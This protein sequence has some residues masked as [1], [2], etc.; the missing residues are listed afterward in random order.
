MIKKGDTKSMKLMKR[1]GSDETPRAMRRSVRLLTGATRAMSLVI[2]V[3]VIAFGAMM[4]SGSAQATPPGSS[5]NTE[6]YDFYTLSSNV[7]A[8]FSEA[9]KPGAKSGLSED[10]GWTNIAASASTGGDLLGYGDEN[11]SSASGWLISKTTGASNVVGYDSLRAKDSEGASYKGVLEYTQYG[12]LLNALGLDST[13]TGLNLHLTN[14][15]FGGIMIMLYLLAGGIDTI[16][17]AVVWILD[18]LNPFRVFYTGVSKASA[19]MADGMT[20][21]QG[22][23]EW[24]K[25]LDTWFSGWYQALVN[26][27]WTVLTPLF[28]FTFLLSALMWKKGQALSGLKKL[29]VRVLFLAFGLPLIGSLYTASLSVMKDATAG[30]GMGSTRVILATFVDFE[31]WAKVNR[32]AV[33]NGAELAWDLNRQAPTG[34][35][36]NNL[37]STSVAINKQSHAGAFDSI[38]DINVSQLGSISVNDE[39]NTSGDETGASVNGGLGISTYGATMDMLLRYMRSDTYQASDFETAIKGRLSRE[40][41]G[42]GDNGARIQKCATTWFNVQTDGSTKP[43]AASGGCSELKASQ[44]PILTVSGGGL[45]AQQYGSTLTFKTEGDSQPYNAVVPGNANLSPLAMYNYLN[46]SF[47]KNALTVYSSSNA[48]SKATRE[49]HGSVNLV[50]S[51]GVNWLYWLNSSVTLLCFVVLGLGYAFGML[52]GAIKNSLHIITAV[53]FA[54]IGSLAGIAKVLIYTFTMITEIIGTMFIYRLVQEIIVS[55]PS[56]FEGGLEHMY[57]S[58]GGFGDFLRN[59]GY[60]TLF[61]AIVS[62][63]VLLIL[64]V[65]MMH[66]RGAFVKGLNEAVTKIVDKFLDTNVLPPSAGG[67][68]M[69]LLSGAG[70]G[71]GSAAANRLMSGRGGLGGSKAAGAGF[72]HGLGVAGGAVA[73][74]SSING[75]D[76][77][78]EVGPGALGS[79][80]SS[81]GGTGGGGL[82]LSDGSGG[83]ASRDGGLSAGGAST[84][85]TTSASD[86]QLA[87]EVDSRG[88]LSEPPRLEAGPKADKNKDAAA[89]STVANGEGDGVSAFTGSIRETMDAHRKADQARRSQLTSGVKAVYHGGKAAVRATAG[90]VAGAAQDGSKAVGELRQAQAKGQEA[91]A[92]RQ[93]AEAPRPVRRVQQPQQSSAPAQAPAQAP[94]PRPAPAQSAAPARGRVP[95]LAAQPSSPQAP[96]SPHLPPTAPRSGTG[97]KPSGGL[98]IPPVK[99]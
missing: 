18:T 68:M 42:N 97:M 9:A 10:E 87:R 95:R 40:A 2:A 90:D 39:L 85:L 60:V 24:M 98:P 57:N 67:K 49:Y 56:I 66:F 77:P 32:L 27:S 15:F 88:G 84:A 25:S 3:M 38:A 64:T 82:L 4:L 41:S 21:G 43:D 76:G 13:S 74:G 1:R 30:A 86:R 69:P 20:G 71:V 23:P 44:N 29:L 34:G 28:L 36:V 93:V 8:Y 80:P 6:K 31:N 94:A 52:T 54:T 45:K 50:G 91:K 99:K 7:S 65:K 55:V 72:A 89:S 63:V 61:T 19:A 48:V 73:G 33:P 12:S 35:S 78:D 75:T 11:I 70:A 59:S 83:I 14:V 37:R 26:L 58:L 22:V 53:P 96:A 92:H 51:S 16:F 81:P 79:G 62:T 47:D 5:G 46:T 17:S